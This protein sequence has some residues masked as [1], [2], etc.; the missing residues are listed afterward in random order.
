[1]AGCIP[2]HFGVGNPQTLQIRHI[3]RAHDMSN[4]QNPTKHIISEGPSHRI[5]DYAAPEDNTKGK[6][7]ML[8]TAF[9][10]DV[11][12]NG[13]VYRRPIDFE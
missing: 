2:K 5:R 8:G 10:T 9:C 6:N 7:I 4:A 12:K 1:M 3:F 11:A 13:F